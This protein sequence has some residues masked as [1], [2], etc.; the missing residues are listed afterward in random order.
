MDWGA[1]GTVG[2]FILTAFAG[3]GV[4]VNLAAKV[5][6]MDERIKEDREKNECQH[7]D[8]YQVRDTVT[9][10][11]TALP[12][13]NRRLEAIERSIEKLTELIQ[14]IRK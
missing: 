11:N 2:G 12:E 10:L 13:M 5:T 6:A 3:Y 8:F 7:K 1:I 9:S 14:E 4:F